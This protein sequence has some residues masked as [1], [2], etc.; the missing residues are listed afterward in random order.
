MLLKYN[1]E[2]LFLADSTRIVCYANRCLNNEQF[3]PLAAHMHLD[4]LSC[5][6]VDA[7]EVFQ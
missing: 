5:M 7:P 2:S 6:E 1:V 4:S 3:W